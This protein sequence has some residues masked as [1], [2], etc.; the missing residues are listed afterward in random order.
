MK[1][2]FY[3]VLRK[4]TN[5]I[6]I[7]LDIDSISVKELLDKLSNQFSPVIKEKLVEEGEVIKGAMILVNGVNILHLDKLNTI[8][9]NSDTVHLFPPVGCGKNL[10]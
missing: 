8:L 3:A 7:I 9:K 10:L 6:E 1:I 4:I 5:N 2:R